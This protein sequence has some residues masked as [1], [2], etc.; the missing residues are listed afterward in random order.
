LRFMLALFVCGARPYIVG[1][2]DVTKYDAIFPGSQFVIQLPIASI[3]PDFYFLFRP[4]RPSPLLSKSHRPPPNAKFGRFVMFA[5]EAA[6]RNDLC[7]S[8][9]L[10][11]HHAHL[12]VH[13]LRQMIPDFDFCSHMAIVTIYEKIVSRVS[14]TTG[15][16]NANNL[17]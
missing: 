17:T 6:S 13:L 14:P 16:I 1:Q 7:P 5:N 15:C 4:V 10:C 11:A 12:F 3:T 8:L 9:R 2:P